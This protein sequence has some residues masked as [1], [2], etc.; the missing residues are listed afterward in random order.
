MINARL[1]KSCIKTNKVKE[2]NPDDSFI[3]QHLLAHTASFT[4]CY[5]LQLTVQRDFIRR[6]CRTL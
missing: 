4:C 1:G 6:F 5:S 3:P 2:E